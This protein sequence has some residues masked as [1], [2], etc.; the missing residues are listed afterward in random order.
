MHSINTR[1]LVI[2]IQAVDALITQTDAELQTA[3]GSNAAD[4]EALLLAYTLAASDLK[5]QFDEA[6]KTISNLPP[7][8]SL[9]KNS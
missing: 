8:D 4:L 2:A 9:A 6:K 7:Y 5:N 1:T 3:T